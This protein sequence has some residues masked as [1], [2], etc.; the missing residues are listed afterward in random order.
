MSAQGCKRKRMFS[1][2]LM[3]LNC[4]CFPLGA[5]YIYCNSR[6]SLGFP[7]VT[8]IASTFSQSSPR[9]HQAAF[10]LVRRLMEETL[11]RGD[12][13]TS[14]EYTRSYIRTRLRHN[15]QEVFAVLFLDNRNRAVRAAS[16]AAD[17][18][19]QYSTHGQPAGSGGLAS[20]ISLSLKR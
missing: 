5:Y 17:P 13:L 9:N 6:Q 7:K 20:M 11:R 15:R 4:R 16:T 8:V 10:E 1:Q 2:K 12:S 18:M 3:E 14:V 19:T